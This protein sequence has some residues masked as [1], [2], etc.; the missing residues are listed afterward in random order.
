MLT[1]EINRK[2]LTLAGDQVALDRMMDDFYVPVYLYFKNLLDKR[3]A[4]SH[5]RPLF[6]GISAPQGVGKTTLT[7]FMRALF[8]AEGK[9]CLSVSIDDFYLTNKNRWRP[10]WEDNGKGKGACVGKLFF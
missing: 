8:A 6:I 4:G 1:D 9:S 3:D 5:S 7:E 10:N 2:K